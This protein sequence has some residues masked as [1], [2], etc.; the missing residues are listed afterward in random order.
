MILKYAA[1]MLTLTGGVMVAAN[2]AWASVRNVNELVIPFSAE[3]KLEFHYGACFY[4]NLFTGLAIYFF[5]NKSHC[6]IIKIL[7]F[8]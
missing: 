7:T 4:L 1:F 5:K 2:I 6:K 3:H 8:T